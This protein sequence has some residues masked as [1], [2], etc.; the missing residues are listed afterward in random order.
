MAAIRDAVESGGYDRIDPRIVNVVYLDISDIDLDQEITARSES[1]GSSSS[2]SS[3]KVP[4]WAI[5][6]MTVVSLGLVVS[7]LLYLG[8]RRPQDTNGF[9]TIPDDEGDGENF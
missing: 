7:L 8:R 6:L 2:S 4:G 3:L 5:V 9:D 1:G